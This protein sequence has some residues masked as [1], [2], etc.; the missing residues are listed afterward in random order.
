MDKIKVCSHLLKYGNEEISKLVIRSLILEKNLISIDDVRLKNELYLYKNIKKEYKPSIISALIVII[1]ASENLIESYNMAKELMLKIRK[2]ITVEN[3]IGINLL[4]HYIYNIDN[5]NEKFTEI[6]MLSYDKDDELYFQKEK[7]NIIINNNIFERI[8]VLLDEQDINFNME[9]LEK[10]SLCEDKKYDDLML[11]YFD[12]IIKKEISGA[13][14][15][16]GNFNYNSIISKNVGDIGEDFL[17]GK[18]SIIEKNKNLI[19]LECKRGKLKLLIEKNKQDEIFE[20]DII[21]DFCID[22]LSIEW[23]KIINEELEKD[24]FQKLLTKLNQEYKSEKVYPK[25]EDVF[26]ALSLVDFNKIKVVIIGQDPYHQEK[27]ANGLCFSVNTGIKN[28]PSLNNIF[29]EL[30][31]EYG[32][33]REDGDLSDWAHQGVLMLNSVLTVRD[34]NPASHSKFGWEIFTDR[35]VGEIGKIERPLVFLL[36]GNYAISKAKNISNEK[37]LILKSNHPSPF[38][39][40]RGFFGNEHFIKTNEFLEKNN[41]KPINWINRKE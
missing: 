26:K 27:Q 6:N 22:N 18:Y 41:I 29:K 14:K 12:K 39:C 17:L 15:L 11:D 23:K 8:C 5:F 28:P 9:L 16:K 36:W 21:N 38:S 35:I 2:N 4:C 13:P 31:K 25:K 10:I 7:I 37:H 40:N 3:K 19:T 32:F 20:K 33:L 34:S 24:Y 1:L 30:E